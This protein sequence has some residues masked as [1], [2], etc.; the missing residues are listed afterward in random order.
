MSDSDDD[1]VTSRRKCNT[2]PLAS[3]SRTVSI[4]AVSDQ[5]AEVDES[6]L[7]IP[8]F[9]HPPVDASPPT[10]ISVGV[11]EEDALVMGLSALTLSDSC[12]KEV[13]SERL[14]TKEEDEGDG[15]VIGDK[16]CKL[17]GGFKLPRT[18]YDTLY[19]YQREGVAWMWSLHESSPAVAGSLGRRTERAGA[20]TPAPM[21]AAVSRAL[22]GVEQSDKLCGGILAD[23][24]GLGKTLQVIS[25][26]SGV[27]HGG[28]AASALVIL[29]VSLISTWRDEMMRFTPKVLVHVLHEQSSAK[30][31]ASVVVKVQEEGGVLLTTYGMLTAAPY[32]FG[33][34]CEDQGGG[35]VEC[36]D[37][38]TSGS[39][40]R[41]VGKS[42]A[43]TTAM[44]MLEESLEEP[45]CWD[46]LIL[47]EGHRIKNP[48]TLTTK[49]ARAIPSHYRLLLT[50]TPIQNNLDELWAL[51][52]FTASGRLLDT[53]PNFNRYLGASIMA[54]RDKRATPEQREAGVNALN[55]LM[56]II[57]PYL[58]R[59]EKAKL[60]LESASGGNG[61]SSRAAPSLDAVEPP[62]QP[63]QPFCQPWLPVQN[64]AQVC[65]LRGP[66][67][68][69]V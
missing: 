40:S 37:S 21:P 33:V 17:P 54:S 34:E 50:G 22:Q 25:L 16:W 18:L 39:K 57:H 63:H 3:I 44:A 13:V 65:A 43:F 53:R 1:I 48:S 2:V 14:S 8:S 32:L 41:G 11:C 69:W 6:I 28:V 68:P 52:D 7:H 45:L 15:W 58:L 23:D 60:L 20:G 46:L 38:E 56:C 51:F 67:G 29:P 64:L 30:A 9:V 24:M 49:A 27:L 35:E 55:E 26:L 19:P 31:R 36:G 62:P 61:G 59:R 4:P 10:E 12:E 42:N 47:D 66:W 5:E